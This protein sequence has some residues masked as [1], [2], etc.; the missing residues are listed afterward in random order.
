M[1]DCNQTTFL[2][3][4]EAVIMH[5]YEVMSL[6]VCKVQTMLQTCALVLMNHFGSMSI[7]DIFLRSR[8]S[9]YILFLSCF[10][11]IFYH[12]VLLSGKTLTSCSLLCQRIGN[13]VLSHILNEIGAIDWHITFVR[14]PPRMHMNMNR[15]KSICFF[16]LTSLASERANNVEAFPCIP[17]VAPTT[18]PPPTSCSQEFLISI[19]VEELVYMHENHCLIRRIR[20][21]GYA[22]L[23]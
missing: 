7:V 5:G 4:C 9:C 23:K 10:V 20:E 8:C 16:F 15:C 14:P 19:I 17:C 12:F 6:H 21:G 22:L 3:A 2:H 11:I 1:H 18:S 13:N